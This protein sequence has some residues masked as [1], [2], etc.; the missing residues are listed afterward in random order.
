[1][2][3]GKGA[4]KTPMGANKKGFDWLIDKLTATG[5][6]VLTA[7]M[8]MTCVDVVGRFFNRPILGAIEIVGFLSTLTVALALP[9][10]HRMDGHIGV[11]L[12]I[13]MFSERTQTVVA[14]CTSILSLLLFSVITWRMFDYAGIMRKSGEVSMSLK[15]PEYVIIYLVGVCFL[16][17]TLII[18]R[19]VAATIKKLKEAK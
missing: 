15:F 9:Y 5:A 7:M 1:M 12:F 6:V 11:E 10:T 18:V 16:I 14:L 3:K 8:L 13:R 19:D 17:F 2:A 4:E